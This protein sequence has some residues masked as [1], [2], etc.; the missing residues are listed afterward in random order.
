MKKQRTKY[1][2]AILKNKVIQ[3]LGISHSIFKK[4]LRYSSHTIQFTHLKLYSMMAFSIFTELYNHHHNRFQNIFVTSKRNPAS[5][6]LLTPKSPIFTSQPTT[7]L[8]SVYKSFSMMFSSFIHVVENLLLKSLRY[9][10]IGK[11]L[12]QSKGTG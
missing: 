7:I 10:Y 4:I 9:C 12:K 1:I 2:K 6:R 11:R 3:G 5:P 8:F